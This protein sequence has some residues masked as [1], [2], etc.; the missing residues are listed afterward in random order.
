MSCVV[1]PMA[2]VC[3]SVILQLAGTGQEELGVVE[4]AGHQLVTLLAAQLSGHISLQIFHA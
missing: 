1:L 2:W 4:Q 3:L